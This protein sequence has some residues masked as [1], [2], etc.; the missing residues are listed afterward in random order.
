MDGE[1]NSLKSRAG[2][3]EVAGVTEDES[4]EVVAVGD[5]DEEDFAA[6]E[7]SAAARVAVRG[8]LSICMTMPSWS[9]GEYGA[10]AAVPK[11]ITPAV[12]DMATGIAGR[13]AWM[14]AMASAPTSVDVVERGG[15]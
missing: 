15:R 14:D 10:E 13:R 1:R 9:S 12:P 6:N 4:G 2:M 7:S 3:A 8:E 5:E 11:S